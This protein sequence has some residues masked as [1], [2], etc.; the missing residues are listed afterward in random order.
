[1]ENNKKRPFKKLKPSA[2][3]S[4]LVIKKT[5]EQDAIDEEDIKLSIEEW[6]ESRRQENIEVKQEWEEWLPNG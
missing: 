4:E 3:I 1:V 2:D 5:K 6:E